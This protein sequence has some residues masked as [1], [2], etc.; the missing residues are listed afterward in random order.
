MDCSTHDIEN[1]LGTVEG[2]IHAIVNAMGADVEYLFMNWAQSNVA[3]DKIEKPTIVY[4]LPPA[5][6][7]DIDSHLREAKDRPS[8]QIAFLA[9]TEFDFDGEQNDGI[10]EEMKRLALQFI[11]T[12]NE[13]GMF[14][15]ISGQLPYQVLYDHLDENV[16][17]IVITPPLVEEDGIMLCDL[18]F[19]RKI[20]N[21][22]L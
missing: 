15:A 5:G 9:S 10:I 7:F 3:F 2:K 8:A 13:S 12:L 22:Q 20:K 18:P 19:Y 17:G 21:E 16:T 1:R 4:V 11:K 6:W 14:E